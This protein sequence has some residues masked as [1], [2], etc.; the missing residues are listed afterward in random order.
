MECQST[1]VLLN[2]PLCEGMN[3]PVQAWVLVCNQD[4]LRRSWGRTDS[5]GAGPLMGWVEGRILGLLPI[6]L[7]GKVSLQRPYTF[8]QICAESVNNFFRE[9]RVGVRR[10]SGAYTGSQSLS[11]NQ[12]AM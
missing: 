5:V 10:G 2:E 8:L 12:E 6:D 9:P 11:Y 7:S 1:G 3:S 4:K